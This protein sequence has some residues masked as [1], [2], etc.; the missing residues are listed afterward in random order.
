M[1]DLIFALKIF[2]AVVILAFL[3]IFLGVPLKV[4]I[5]AYIATF[6]I[7]VVGI[8]IIEKSKKKK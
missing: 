6:V 1:P 8:F 5:I 4:Y 3:G 2:F 7:C